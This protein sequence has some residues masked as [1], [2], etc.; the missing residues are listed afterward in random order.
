MVNIKAMDAVHWRR[1]LN[2][3]AEAIPPCTGNISTGKFTL[4]ES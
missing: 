2:A 3:L 4:R 1:A